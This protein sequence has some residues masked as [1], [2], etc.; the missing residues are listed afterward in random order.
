MTKVHRVETYVSPLYAERFTGLRRSTLKSC[1]RRGVLG[2]YRTNG[3]H[4]R[5][6]LS[7]LRALREAPARLYGSAR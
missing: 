2:H 4:R 3:G 7:E 1:V 6:A 5:Y